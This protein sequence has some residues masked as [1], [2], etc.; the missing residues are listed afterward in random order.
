MGVCRDR[1][2]PWLADRLAELGGRSRVRDDRRGS[3]GRHGTQRFSS[4]PKQGHRPGAD[5]RRAGTDGG[6]SDGRGGRALPGARDGAGRGAGG[7]HRT[8]RQAIAASAGRTSIHEALRIGTRKQA[9]VPVGATVL[10]PV[11]TAPG[12]VGAAG[13]VRRAVRRAVRRWSYCRDRRAS[14]S[15][16]GAPPRRRMRCRAGDRRD[17]TVYEQ[18]TLRLFGI[19]ELEIA[20]DTARGRNA[21]GRAGQAGGH[22]MPETWRGRDRDAL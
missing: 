8:D 6:R 12:L 2:G 14:C 21:R 1:N 13:S 15:R 11:G 16:C 20:A 4:W 19:P 3:T 22:D 10:E 9:T 7:A 18:R 17:A 5:Q